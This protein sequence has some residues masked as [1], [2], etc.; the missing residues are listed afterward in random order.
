MGTLRDEHVRQFF[1]DGFV[2]LRGVFTRSEVDVM[3]AA[4][5]RLRDTAQLLRMSRM[6]RGARFVLGADAAGTTRIERVV[7][8]VAT[9]PDLDR[10]GTDRR[11]LQPVARLLGSSCMEQLISQA[12]FKLPGDGVAF[13]WHQDSRHRRYGTGMWRDVNGRGSYVQTVI[14]VGHDLENSR[15][16]NSGG[17]D[18]DNRLTAGT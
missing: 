7:W 10:F 6:Y 9:E 3:R 14:V 2:V 15:R 1:D 8:C 18:E 11:L 13:P 12:H 5:D 16:R 17:R 4:F